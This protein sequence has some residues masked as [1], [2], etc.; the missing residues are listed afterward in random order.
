M[1]KSSQFSTECCATHPTAFEYESDPRQAEK[2]L[3]GLNVD[4]NCNGASTPG[5]KLLIEQLTKYHQLP[6][7]GHT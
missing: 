5:L 2:L 7:D 1:R 4:S 6:T 3:E